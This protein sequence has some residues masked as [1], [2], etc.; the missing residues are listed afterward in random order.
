MC[1]LGDRVDRAGSFSSSGCLENCSFL[2]LAE[3]FF[4]K[5]GG[6]AQ[7]ESRAIYLPSLALFAAAFSFSAAARSLVRSPEKYFCSCQESSRSGKY[8]RVRTA[9]VAPPPRLHQLLHAVT[10]GYVQCRRRNNLLSLRYMRVFLV[11]RLR[12]SCEEI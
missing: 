8:K 2:P 10:T 5:D 11:E 12:D 3:T 4:L 7:V 6:K 1:K 9:C